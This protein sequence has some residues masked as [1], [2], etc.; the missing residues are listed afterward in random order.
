MF[1]R[2]HDAPLSVQWGGGGGGGVAGETHSPCLASS[3]GRASSFVVHALLFTFLLL[4]IFLSF[5]ALE[6]N[7][8]LRW[9]SV[10]TLVFQLLVL[11]A[12]LTHIVSIGCSSCSY[13][14]CGCCCS[15]C[16]YLACHCRCSE[17]SMGGRGFTLM[18]T[19]RL[20][21]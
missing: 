16:F 17:Q 18:R 14:S 13:R 7:T 20:N 4:T 12:S 15:W 5:L 2:F 11:L 3:L 10:F 19:H 6:M 21:T 9:V 8:L 1:F